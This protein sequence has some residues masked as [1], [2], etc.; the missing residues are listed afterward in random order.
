MQAIKQD[1]QGKGNGIDQKDAAPCQP[2]RH[3]SQKEQ[4]QTITANKSPQP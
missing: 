1:M 2:S 4:P 3:K